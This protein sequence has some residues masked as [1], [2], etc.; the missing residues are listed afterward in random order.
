[1]ALSGRSLFDATRMLPDAPVQLKGLPNHWADLVAGRTEYKVPGILPENMPDRV[2]PQ[3]TDQ[4]LVGRELLAEMVDRVGFAMSADEGRPN[5]NGIYMKV[6]PKK[7]VARVEMVATDGHR[8]ARPVPGRATPSAG[9]GP[10][11]GA[12]DQFRRLDQF[13]SQIAVGCDQ[14]SDHDRSLPLP[15]R[16]CSRLMPQKDQI[17]KRLR[18][19]KFFT[20]PQ[21]FGVS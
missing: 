19:Q 8:L 18:K 3:T 2:P 15:E 4:V 5:L 17:R 13:A 6:E 9:L 11:E 21:T 10:L 12:A 14:H 20:K 16:G 7:A 1:M